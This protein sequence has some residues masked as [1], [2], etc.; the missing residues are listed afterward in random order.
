MGTGRFIDRGEIE[1]NGAANITDVLRTVTGLRVIQAGLS[2]TVVLSG[3]PAGRGLEPQ[4]HVRF[5]LDGMVIHADG[6]VNRLVPLDW[7][8]A[9]EVYRRAAEMPAEFL[10]DGTCGAV[11]IWTRRG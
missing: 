5:Y 3:N 4:C 8:E 1:R 2:A 11:A 9:I 6:D 7:V 10:S